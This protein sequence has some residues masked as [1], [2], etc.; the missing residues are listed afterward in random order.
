MRVMEKNSKSVPQVAKCTL[1]LTHFWYFTQVLV[2]FLFKKHNWMLS[3]TYSETSYEGSSCF[4]CESPS[5]KKH[6]EK[7][8]TDTWRLLN[9]NKTFRRPPGGLLNVSC[10]FNLRP[11]STGLSGLLDDIRYPGNYLYR[12]T[13]MKKTKAGR[14]PE[15]WPVIISG[16]SIQL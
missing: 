5:W 2:C 1:S 7:N 16:E 12:L 15:T 9:V 4:L 8:P 11:V 13:S 10:K 6:L 3:W 14:M